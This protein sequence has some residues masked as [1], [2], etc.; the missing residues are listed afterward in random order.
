MPGRR[1][2]PKV[3]IAVAAVI[4]LVAVGV[5]VAIA[6]T[7]G[8]SSSTTTTPT[9]G[10]LQNGLPGT[11]EVDRLFRGIPQSGSVLVRPTRL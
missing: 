9:R 5:G 7:G 6:F 4:V 10:S 3:L 8:D 11:E 2:S 1:A